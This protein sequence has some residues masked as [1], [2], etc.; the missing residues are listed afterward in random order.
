MTVPEPEGLTAE[1]LSALT[2]GGFLTRRGPRSF[3]VEPSAWRERWEEAVE[4][5]SK[6]ISAHVT[7]S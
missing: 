5:V 1:I 7:P 6:V 4:I 3:K 2:K